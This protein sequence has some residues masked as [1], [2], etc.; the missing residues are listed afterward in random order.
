MAI[1]IDCWYYAIQFMIALFGFVGL[2]IFFAWRK[3]KTVI[4]IIAVTVGYIAFMTIASC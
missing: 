3:K 1:I 2:G 4:T